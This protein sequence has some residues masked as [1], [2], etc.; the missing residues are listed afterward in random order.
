MCTKWKHSSTTLVFQVLVI[1]PWIGRRRHLFTTRRQQSC[2]ST[3]QIS[4]ASCHHLMICIVRSPLLV[5]LPF[6][7]WLWCY[8]SFPSYFYWPLKSSCLSSQL[9]FVSHFL[10]V[11]SPFPSRSAVWA[12]AHGNMD[13]PSVADTHIPHF[14]HKLHFTPPNPPLVLNMS[15]PPCSF[16][17][18]VFQ[19]QLSL[20]CLC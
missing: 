17:P 18:N 5:H 16:H 14:N 4:H 1:D 9:P 8:S 2:A 3:V 19:H 15:S 11:H 7:F 6:S 10:G 20:Q 13:L 12:V